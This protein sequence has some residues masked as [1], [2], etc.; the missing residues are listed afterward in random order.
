MSG[1]LQR[2]SPPPSPPPSQ[3]PSP[4]PPSPSPFL[5]L[6]MTNK[7]WTELRPPLN[8]WDETSKQIFM[9]LYSCRYHR[10][11]QG[12][13]IVY[14]H[15][16]LL[17]CGIHDTVVTVRYYRGCREIESEPDENQLS[18]YIGYKSIFW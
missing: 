9:R 2:Y 5:W 17:W 15:K 13:P 18:Y 14:F 6:W 7:W 12:I 4:P 10:P 1:T 8:E 16:I 11:F 3:P